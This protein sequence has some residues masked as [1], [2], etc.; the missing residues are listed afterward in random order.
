[1]ND[2][3]R[4]Q[5]ES[6]RRSSVSSAAESDV[7]RNGSQYVHNISKYWYKPKLS[8]ADAISLLKT[9][10]PGT[11]LIR[12]SQDFRGSY[13]LAIKVAK[14][15]P[16]VRSAKPGKL[17]MLYIIQYFR[18]KFYFSERADPNAEL[19]RH[20]LIERTPTGYVQ[21]KGCINEPDFGKNNNQFTLLTTIIQNNCL[22]QLLYQH[23][24]LPFALPCKVA[25]PETDIFDEYER[26]GQDVRK[27]S[28][29]E[30]LDKGTVKNVIDSTESRHI[31]F[32]CQASKGVSEYHSLS[33]RR[34]GHTQSFV[35]SFINCKNEKKCALEQIMKS[36]VKVL[37]ETNLLMQHQIAEAREQTRLLSELVELPNDL[38]KASQKA[39]N[40][41][42]MEIN[43]VDVRGIVP[44]S[45]YTQ[46]A[47]YCIR[48]AYGESA[49]F[50]NLAT[51]V[52]AHLHK[53]SI[54]VVY[55]MR[56]D[57]VQSLQQMK[58]DQNKRV[59]SPSHSKRKVKL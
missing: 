47:R 49:S 33:Y 9:K 15:P 40:V 19:V 29:K 31:E 43:G 53:I 12:D 32:F 42:R 22:L 18:F 39:A 41:L 16:F 8:R 11:F 24:L 23:S 25:L 27:P 59:S 5:E 17:S 36:Y 37:D 2:S 34:R 46:T 28:P 21:L 13:G 58:Y 44:K 7:L 10:P 20:Y 1:M 52:L 26:G 14:L 50:E 56:K 3:F 30:L 45:A 38:L 4:S 6:S 51:G 55:C 54:S 57:I 35:V 48:L